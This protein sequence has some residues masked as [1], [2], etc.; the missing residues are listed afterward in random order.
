[1][2]RTPSG[3]I[4][5]HI[6]RLAASPAVPEPDDG[7]LLRRFIAERDETAFTI[8]LARHGRLVWGVCRRVLQHEHEA[9]DAFQATFLVFTRRAD[10]IRK[11]T[12]VSCFLYGIAYRI[13]LRIKQGAAKQ[14][15]N[16]RVEAA[17]SPGT[18]VSEVACRELQA[19][20]DEELNRLPEKYRA[21]FVLC[22]LEGKSRAEAALELGCRQGTVSSRVAEARTRLRRR[23]ERRG[24]ALSAALRLT[25]LASTA[26]G[27]EVPASLLEATVQVVLPATGGGAASPAVLAAA[28][29]ILSKASP[30]SLKLVACLLLVASLVCAAAAAITQNAKEREGIEASRDAQLAPP[31]SERRPPSGLDRYGDALPRGAIARLGTVRLRHGWMTYALAYSPDGKMLASAGVGRG[32]CLWDAASGKLLHLPIPSGQVLGV[33]FS[34]DGKL[35]A[36]PDCLFD[37]TTGLKIRHLA[38]HK[39]GGSLCVAFA[40]D[41]KTVATGG[42]DK[43]VRLWDVA[44]GRELR[45]LSG[46]DGSVFSVAYSPD[47]NIVAAAGTDTTIHLWDTV[48]G[49]NRG[50]LTGH[51]PGGGQ[52]TFRIAFSPDGKLLASGA[53]DQTVRLWD[54]AAAKEQ[55]ILGAALGEVRAVAFAPDGKSVV[56]GYGDGRIRAWDVASG[57]EL[58]H[59]QP[60][61]R[62]I[63]VLAFAPDG[64]TIATVADWESAIRQWDIH[65]GLERSPYAGPHGPVYWLAFAPDGRSLFLTSRDQTL[66]RWDWTRDN[67][68][69]LLNWRPASRYYAACLTT[70]GP[71]VA[72]YDPDHRIRVWDGTAGREPRVIGEHPEAVWALGFSPDGRLLAS[73]GEDLC[74]RLWDL[75]TDREVRKWERLNDKPFGL[76]FSP[77]GKTFVTGATNWGMRVP[78]KGRGLCHWDAVSGKELKPF[79]CT[80]DAVPV[81]FSPDGTLLAST[82][83]FIPARAALWDVAAG[84]ERSLEQFRNCSTLGFSQDNK[85]LAVGNGVRE[86]SVAVVEVTSGQEVCRFGGH[87]SGVTSV[88]FSPDGRFLAT[89]GGDA[90]VLMFDLATRDAAGTKPADASPAAN[91]AALADTDAAEAFAAARSLAADPRRAVPFLRQQLR[92]VPPLDEAGR[93]SLK[94]WLADLDSDDFTVRRRAA[95]EL[96]KLGDRAGRALQE[97]LHAGATPEARRQIV[98]LLEGLSTW[99]PDRLRVRRAVTSLEQMRTPE[100]RQLLE[101]LAGGSPEALPARE[102]EAALARLKQQSAN[103]P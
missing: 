94:R 70:G 60:Y 23:L 37:V 44:T 59:S 89:A 55:R 80:G 6:H 4:L 71:M 33:A 63:D 8:L 79:D 84:R 19:I 58:H 32:L 13:A 74:I 12:S 69:I 24:V 40:P 54:V 2:S 95:Q 53:P 57:K 68:T 28:D 101:E 14:R 81:A 46:Y 7:E 51:K 45:Q 26:S 34:P 48:T 49:A 99:S 93:R 96:E 47:G 11:K 76:V 1:M 73:A 86:N 43:L 87:F 100:A 64:K 36:A 56:S 41:G 78:L 91:W 52:G 62:A 97:S 3:A 5:R 75:R 20:V 85:Y 16:D 38:G 35:V 22:C 83:G 30:A 21:P 9:E 102:A 67:E 88:A 65:T 10:A 29:R 77:D 50:V 39:N 61:A 72:V 82:V 66:R 98:I 25:D 18:V 15:A 90:T 42:H 17:V 92:A 103:Q 31:I 27:G